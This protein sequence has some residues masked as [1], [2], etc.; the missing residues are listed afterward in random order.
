MPRLL[1]KHLVQS[2]CGQPALERRIGWAVAQRHEPSTLRPGKE[3]CPQNL[4]FFGRSSHGLVFVP[5][6]FQY[7]PRTG[8][9]NR[10]LGRV[11]RT[12]SENPPSV[13]ENLRESF[14]NAG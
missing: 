12:N 3:R 11:M 9:V 10:A 8:G 2:P 13:R 6:V 14:E 4:D 1:G 7:A 5:D